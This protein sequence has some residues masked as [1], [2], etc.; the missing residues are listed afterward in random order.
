MAKMIKIGVDIKFSP[1]LAISM[2]KE[3]LGDLTFDSPKLLGEFVSRLGEEIKRLVKEF[4]KL[5]SEKK[6]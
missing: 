5:E 6:K 1:K 4:K 2:G 3:K